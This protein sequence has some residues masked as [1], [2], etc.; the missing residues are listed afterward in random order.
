MSNAKKLN[1]LGIYTDDLTSENLENWLNNYNK[2]DYK[3]SNP[4][5]IIVDRINEICKF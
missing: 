4:I 2:I 3:W 1:K 5:E